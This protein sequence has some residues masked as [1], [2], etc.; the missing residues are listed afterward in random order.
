MPLTRKEIAK[1]DRWQLLNK[2]RYHV[3]PGKPYQQVC[4]MTTKYLRYLLESY[5]GHN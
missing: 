1:L 3:W 4:R 5:N 2:L